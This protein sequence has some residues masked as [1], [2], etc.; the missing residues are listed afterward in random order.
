MSERPTVWIVFPRVSPIAP[1]RVKA[2]TA[3]ALKAAALP[4]EVMSAPRGPRNKLATEMM[5]M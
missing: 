3:Q 5:T 1:G 4:I 2:Y